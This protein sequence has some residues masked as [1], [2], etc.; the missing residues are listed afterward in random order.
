MRLNKAQLKSCGAEKNTLFY[1][2]HKDACP[3]DWRQFI[4][5]GEISGLE[6]RRETLV[7]TVVVTADEKK[8]QFDVTRAEIMFTDEV[9]YKSFMFCR[10]TFASSFLQ[11]PRYHFV[12]TWKLKTLSKTENTERCWR[13]FG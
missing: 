9:M 13:H 12:F 4:Q 10:V 11:S 3:A 1:T 6:R 7:T 5:L 8:N 2:W